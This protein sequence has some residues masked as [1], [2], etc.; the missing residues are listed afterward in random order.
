MAK[1]RVLSDSMVAFKLSASIIY[2]RS[3]PPTMTGQRFASI[4]HSAR[5]QCYTLV[6][7]GPIRVLLRERFLPLA[8][9]LPAGGSS[10]GIRTRRTL[11]DNLT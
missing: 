6:N 10:C 5:P 4:I 1:I 8:L 7:R 9:L 2:R 11:R 3:S